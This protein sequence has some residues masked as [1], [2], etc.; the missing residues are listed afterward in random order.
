MHENRRKIKHDSKKYDCVD[1]FALLFLR[2]DIDETV[3][4]LKDITLR[5]EQKKAT[6]AYERIARDLFTTVKVLKNEK[7]HS[8]HYLTLLTKSDS[9]DLLKL[10]DSVLNL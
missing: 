9:D 6:V 7:T 5:Q 8:R 4:S 1:R 3:A 2:H 10:N